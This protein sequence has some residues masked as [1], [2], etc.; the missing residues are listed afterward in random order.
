VSGTGDIPHE[1]TAPDGV[2]I[3]YRL[4]RPGRPRRVLVLLHG[5]ASNMTRWS[6]FVAAT[7]L[8]DSWDL[9]RVDLRGQG[10][11]LWRGRVGMAEWCADLAAILDAE[12]YPRAVVAGH[13][14]G[15]NI[16]VEFSVRH[17]ARTAGVIL[18]EPM[19]PDA[20]AGAMGRIATLRPLFRPAVWLVRGLNR[21]G[22]HRRRLASLDLEALDRQTRAAIAA[23]GS[24]ERLLARYASPWLDLRTTATAPYLQAL[25]AV[26]QPLP[27]LAAIKS[28][29][30]ALLSA[31]ST[32][33]D[34]ARTRAR[35]RAVPACRVLM[36]PARHWI[37]TEQPEAMRSSI[38]EWCQGLG[39]AA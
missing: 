22:L 18:I 31:G 14:L 27:D 7:S 30:L 20:L 23:A 3:A 2:T 39:P 12:G 25:L 36:L 24:S 5:L 21:L 9:L 6:E 8:R 32:F 26:T 35:L 38:E 10:A 33:S 28:P 1:L 13:C 19:L 17:P 16:A 11:S 4:W 29:V 15:A 37:P 34:P